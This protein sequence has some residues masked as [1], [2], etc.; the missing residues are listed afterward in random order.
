M[1]AAVAPPNLVLGQASAKRGVV[2]L[3]ATV[4]AAGT[5][6]VVGQGL[7]PAELAFSGAGSAV[8]RLR[9]S[10]PGERALTRS[11]SG[12]L[13]IRA[14]AAFAPRSGEPA[15]AVTKTLAFRRTRD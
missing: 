9:L 5:L 14:R 15:S 10:R 12:R 1:A 7:R 13:L 8:L 11:K 3:P 2:A 4:P 6:T